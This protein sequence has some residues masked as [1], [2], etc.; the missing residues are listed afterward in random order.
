MQ[1]LWTVKRKAV[2]FSNTFATKNIY[3]FF[4][5]AVG[6]NLEERSVIIFLLWKF[7]CLIKVGE[8]T[9]DCLEKKESYATPFA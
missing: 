6:T 3:Q 8:N 1:K 2:V 7:D 9:N 5:R 4:L